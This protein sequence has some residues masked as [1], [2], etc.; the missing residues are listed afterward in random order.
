LLSQN[1]L[2]GSNVFTY[3]VLCAIFSVMGRGSQFYIIHNMRYGTC[4]TAYGKNTVA[5]Y[6]RRNGC[7]FNDHKLNAVIG[8]QA[9]VFSNRQG[10]TYIV[11]EKFDG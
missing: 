7:R 8:D 5:T 1:D 6:L 2:F 3:R 11:E 9:V 4:F 10:E